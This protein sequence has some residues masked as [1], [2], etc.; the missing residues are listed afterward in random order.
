MFPPERNLSAADESPAGAD[1]ARPT[2]RVAG[3]DESASGQGVAALRRRNGGGCDHEPQGT[4]PWSG[5]RQAAV[6]RSWPTAAGSSAAPPRHPFGRNRAG[7]AGRRTRPI[8]PKRAG[9]REGGRARLGRGTFF[10]RLI[11][12][13]IDDRR[14]PVPRAAASPAWIRHCPR[15][16]PRSDR[17]RESTRLVYVE[18]DIAGRARCRPPVDGQPPPASAGW[19]QPRRRRASRTARRTRGLPA[20]SGRRVSPG[21]SARGREP[22]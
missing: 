8:S 10:P 7:V 6:A 5:Y 4:Q 19:G 13:T 22:W 12:A 15:A 16:S 21:C 17:R 1:G 14:H 9:G 20:S 2:A 18:E 3:D 11:A